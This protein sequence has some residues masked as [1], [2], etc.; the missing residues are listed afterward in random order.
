MLIYGLENIGGDS[1][2]RATQ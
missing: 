2:S 1:L